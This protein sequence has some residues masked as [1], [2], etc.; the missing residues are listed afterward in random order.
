[1]FHDFSS[2]FALSWLQLAVPNKLQ[3]Y[4]PF[5]AL[6]VPNNLQKAANDY[7]DTT[8]SSE[9]FPGA[10]EKLD[11]ANDTLALVVTI[12]AFRTPPGCMVAHL[13]CCS[14]AFRK[15]GSS[16]SSN[17]CVLFVHAFE[18]CVCLLVLRGGRPINQLLLSRSLS[19]MFDVGMW[20]LQASASHPP[21]RGGMG[22]RSCICVPPCPLGSLGGPSRRLWQCTRS[23]PQRRDGCYFTPAAV[24][25]YF[26]SAGRGPPTNEFRTAP[27]GLPEVVPHPGP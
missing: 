8:Q 26:S 20:G 7:G 14:D 3:L 18:V 15:Y 6:A 11:N 4:A 2:V 25:V 27:E 21:G 12:L 24:Y 10:H 13:C 1:M 22:W 17:V 16:F 19:A 9:S 23:L 5:L